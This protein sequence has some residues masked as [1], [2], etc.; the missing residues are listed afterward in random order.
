[1]TLVHS[2]PIFAVADVRAAAKYYGEVLGFSGEWFWG[3]PPTFGGV[4][5]GHVGVMFCLQPELVGKIAGHQHAFFVTK[6]DQLYQRHQQAGAQIIEPVADKPWGLREYTV[7]DCNGY[8]LRFGESITRH[9]T[10]PK[11]PPAEIR[12]EQRLP[13]LAE[14]TRLVKAVGWTGFVNLEVAPQALASS[15]FGVVACQGERVIAAGRV[16][17]DGAIFFYLQDVM[18]LPEF[19]RQGIGNALVGELMIELT[20]R[21]PRQAFIGLFTGR[22]L[23]GFYEQFGFMGPETFLYGM[24]Y[25]KT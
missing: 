1:M 17:G 18:V 2:E 21:A 5:W 9:A 19:Q 7:R 10:A 23:A 20:R 24:S 22:N 3:D 4:R 8:H 14:Y 25:R 16:V 15:L 13:T 11:T 6:V 12:F